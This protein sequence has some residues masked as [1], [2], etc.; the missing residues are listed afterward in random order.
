MKSNKCTLIIS[1]ILLCCLVIGTSFA[2]WTTTK[3]QQNNNMFTSG[4]LSVAYENETG[5]ISLDKAYPITDIEGQSQEGYSFTLKNKCDEK[6]SYVVNLDVFNDPNVINLSQED[7]NLGIDSR[8]ARTLN[9]YED[10]DIYN[11]TA[12]YA[13]KIYSGVLAAN[14]E[15]THNIKMWVDVNA[16]NEVQK[17]QFKSQ[18]FV[19]VGQ[20]IA[21]TEVSPEECFVT[22][23]NTLLKYKNYMCSGDVVVPQYINEVEITNIEVDAFIDANVLWYVDWDTFE[24]VFVIFD[25][26][27]YDSIKYILENIDPNELWTDGI[28]YVKVSDME[29][30]DIA[31]SG[32]RNSDYFWLKVPLGVDISYYNGSVTQQDLIYSNMLTNQD[33]IADNK[34]NFSIKSLDL[35]R[36]KNLKYIRSGLSDYNLNLAKLELPEGLESISE[37]FAY[38]SIEKLYLPTTLEKIESSVFVGNK[39]EE[40]EFNSELTLDKGAFRNNNI[41]KITINNTIVLGESVFSGNPNL[42]SDNIY[43]GYFSNNTL[44]DFVAAT[45]EFSE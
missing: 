14:E 8:V 23:G 16:G 41:N 6:V 3:K 1:I 38:N 40:I 45:A 33:L 28:R 10:A 39:L 5:T 43:I 25:E 20:N 26:E 22:N 11:N 18:I 31:L 44:E 21:S 2:W 17:S 24:T 4:C 9:N 15:Y 36:L 13:K 42:T 29:D 27:N 19:I 12:S 30:W 34:Y 32:L 35:S 37:S 7:V